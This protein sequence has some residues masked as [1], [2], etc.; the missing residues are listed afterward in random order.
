MRTMGVLSLV[1]LAALTGAAAKGAASGVA[2]ELPTAG[3]SYVVVVSTSYRDKK[4]RICFPR[5]WASCRRG[6]P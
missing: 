5:S 3:S 2:L 6:P 1:V 4:K